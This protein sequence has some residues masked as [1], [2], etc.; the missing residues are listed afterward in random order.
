MILL[1]P[2]A[3][4]GRV[5][6]RR[7]GSLL[8]GMAGLCLLA[9]LFLPIWHIT[10]D[11]PQYPEGMG[12]FI[13]ARTLSGQNPND[14]DIINQLNHYIGMKAIKPDTIPELKIIAPLIAFFS[15]LCFAAALRPKVLFLA[16]LLACLAGMGA[17]GMYDFWRWEYDYGHDLDPRAAIRIPGMSYQP[18]LIGTAKLLNFT[19]TSW[20]ASGGY[21][22]FAAGALIAL[23]LL[24]V[25][26]ASF[27]S[28][29]GKNMS[30]IL[31]SRL[32][33]ARGLD[34]IL[35]LLAL[36]AL[37][38][39][40]CGNGGP[41]PI[42]WGYDACHHCKMALIQKGFAAQRINEKGKVFK[43]DA[44]E[45]LVEN[46]KTNPA[47]DGEKLYVSDWSRP[48]ATLLPAQEAA[49][50]KGGRIPSPMGGNLAGFAAS[51]SARIFQ[52]R[53]GGNLLAWGDILPR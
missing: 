7:A 6:T 2:K 52:E 20:P 26:R 16:L 4:G 35:P 12:M 46:L 45:C 15:L 49:Y 37:L 18:P 23:A 48:D 11:A 28:A 39:S 33:K 42:E 41:S 3:V 29:I 47:G 25:W 19:S 13:W 8:L 9:S 17:V 34:S 51:D 50:L 31:F 36:A 5:Q 1:N 27:K 38:A 43:F 32:R 53:M 22:L 40:G 44:I 21:L 30:A 14:L 24:L 10:L